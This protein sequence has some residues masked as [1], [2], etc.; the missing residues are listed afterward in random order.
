MMR[1]LNLGLVLAGLV[2]LALPVHGQEASPPLPDRNPQ[3][4]APPTGD[5]AAARRP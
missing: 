3:R 4:A 1:R 2:M 5:V